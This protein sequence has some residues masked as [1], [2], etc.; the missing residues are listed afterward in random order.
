VVRACLIDVYDT[1]LTSR[2]VSRMET[3]ISPL[4]IAIGDWIAAWDTM[5]EDRDRG[6]ITV[7]DSMDR[8]LRQLGVEPEPGRAAALARRDGELARA[9]IRLCDDTLPF[10]AWLRSNGVSIALVSNCADP[11]RPLLDHLGVPPLVDAMV[12]SCEV[13]SRKPYPDIYVTALEVLGVAAVD[14]VFIDD[15]P[16]FCAGARAVGIRALQIAR[17]EHRTRPSGGDFP[18]IH[19]LLEAKPLLLSPGQR[20]VRGPGRLWQAREHVNWC[21]PA[22][23]GHRRRDH[24]SRGSLLPAGL[25]GP[26][27]GA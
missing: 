25:P 4:G 26:G 21:A 12:L 2:Y 5:H 17:D 9:T 19:T 18:I 22:C 1:I 16:A 10:L 27:D 3:L 11:T 20:R 13:G 24:R 15:Q 7:A 14:A 6:R 8:T 23:G